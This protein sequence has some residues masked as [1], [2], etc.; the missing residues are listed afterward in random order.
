MQKLKEY[1][2]IY[3]KK[4]KPRYLKDY[5]KADIYIITLSQEVYILHLQYIKANYKNVIVSKQDN[6]YIIRAKGL[7]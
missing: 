7:I 4:V 6:Y 1:N 2:K 3:S 5:Q